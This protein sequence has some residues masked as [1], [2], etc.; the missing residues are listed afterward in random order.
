[1]DV[2]EIP[3]VTMNWSPAM[4]AFG[5]RTTWMAGGRVGRREG[6]EGDGRR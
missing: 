1:V 6:R 2:P 5:P 4:M 3:L